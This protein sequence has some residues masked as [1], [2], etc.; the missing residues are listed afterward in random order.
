MEEL[1]DEG[2][3]SEP[4]LRKSGSDWLGVRC[5]PFRSDSPGLG[6]PKTA[7]KWRVEIG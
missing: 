6:E 4:P 1:Q 2:L 7:R 5:T 3:E